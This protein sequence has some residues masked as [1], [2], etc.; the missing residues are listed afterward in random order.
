MDDESGSG[1]SVCRICAGCNAEI[2]HGRFL[3]CM[4]GIW[5]PLVYSFPCLATVLTINPATGRSIMQDEM[6]ARIS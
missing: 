3:S 5:H 4:R 1:K 6:F 2:G